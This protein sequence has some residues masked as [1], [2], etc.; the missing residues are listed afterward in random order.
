MKALAQVFKTEN[1]AVIKMDLCV[2]LALYL[3]VTV[4]RCH[5]RLRAVSVREIQIC[6]DCKYRY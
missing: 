3:N 1:T 4:A 6:V 5:L 2:V